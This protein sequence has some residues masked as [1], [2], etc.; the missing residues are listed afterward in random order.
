MGRPMSPAATRW[1]SRAVLSSKRKTWATPSRSP[2]WPAASTICRHSAAFMP[3][4]FSQRTGLPAARAVSTSCRWQTFGV[5][6]RTASTS[7]QRLSSSVEEKTCG[8]PNCSALAR[9][10]WESRRERATTLQFCARAK[11]GINRLTACN[12]NPAMPK[13]IIES[14]GPLGAFYISGGRTSCSYLRSCQSS[15]LSHVSQHHGIDVAAA[16]HR[17]IY[18]CGGERLGM[19]KKG[20]RSDRATWFRQGLRISTQ[21]TLR[22][23]NFFL[24]HAYN[25]VDIGANVFESNRSDALGSKAVGDGL[26]D[27][28]SREG[29]DLTSPQAD[30][31]STR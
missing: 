27:S 22:L 10:W 23:E 4:G 19:E 26:R 29:D 14:G 2:A 30:R 12:P 7:G 21:G 11:P 5:V 16:D 13:R 31:K 25:V 3:I 17:D 20:G 8:I 15:A 28:F 9:A 6:T 1:R 24:G 18:F